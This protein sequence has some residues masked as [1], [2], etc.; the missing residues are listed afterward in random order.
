MIM[1]YHQVIFKVPHNI[2]NLFCLDKLAIFFLNDTRMY[3]L[4]QDITIRYFQF[5]LKIIEECRKFQITA[6]WNETLFNPLKF[7]YEAIIP[8]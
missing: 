5:A 3:I 7:G 1:K 4:L 2:L 8:E 6:F